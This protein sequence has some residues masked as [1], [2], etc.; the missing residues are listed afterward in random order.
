[1]RP[2]QWTGAAAFPAALLLLLATH[3]PFLALPFYWDELGQ[4][5]PASLDLFQHGWWI[6][7]STLPNSHPPG[8]MAYLAGVWGLVGYSIPVTRVAML[9]LAAVGVVA[10]W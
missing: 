3:F 2:G 10:V 4:F 8:V 9:C 7:R 1:M 6:P 5:V